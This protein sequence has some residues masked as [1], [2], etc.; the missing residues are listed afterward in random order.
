[1]QKETIIVSLGGSLVAPNEIDTAFLKFILRG[2]IIRIANE[3]ARII[4]GQRKTFVAFSLAIRIP[5]ST[6][7]DPSSSRQARGSREQAEGSSPKSGGTTHTRR[8][9]KRHI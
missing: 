8:S 1:M 7:F 3:N 6:A 2:S 9:K 4:L 5:G